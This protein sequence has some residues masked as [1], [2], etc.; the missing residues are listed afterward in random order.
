M[1]GIDAA[2]GAES[3]GVNLERRAGAVRGVGE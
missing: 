2:G 3:V 1:L